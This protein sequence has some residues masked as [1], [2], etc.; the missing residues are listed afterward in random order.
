MKTYHQTKLR[1]CALAAAFLFA[2]APALTAATVQWE[3]D[4]EHKAVAAGGNAMPAKSSV[5]WQF[6]RPDSAFIEVTDT[7]GAKLNIFSAHPTLEKGRFYYTDRSYGGAKLKF[8]EW[9][10]GS[11]FFELTSRHPHTYHCTRD[12]KVLALAPVNTKRDLTPDMTALGF[13]RDAHEPFQFFGENPAD[14]FASFTKNLRQGDTLALPPWVL[15]AGFDVPRTPLPGAG[16]LLYNGLRFPAPWP[17]KVDWSHWSSDLPPAEA[18][19]LKNRPAVV[20]IDIGRQLFVDDFLVESTDLEREFHYPEKFAGNPVLKPETEIELKGS[21]DLAVAA[22]KSGGLWWSPEKQLFELWY[23]AGWVRTI[24]YA[25]SRDGIHWHRPDL[26]L[27]PG[28]NQVLPAGIPS[29]SYSVVRDYDTADPRKKF[30]LFLRAGRSRDRVRYATSPDGI[31]WGDIQTGGL[32]GDRSTMFYNPFR[33]K[34]VFTLRWNSPRGRARAY[35]ETSDFERGIHWLPD[36]PFPWARA[37]KLD[38]PDPRI[39]DKPQLYNLDAVAY[40]SLMLGCFEILHGPDNNIGAAQG[41]PKFTGLHFAYSRDGFHWHRPD[42]KMAVNSEQ[43]AG[44]WDRGYVQSLNNLCVIRGDKI[45]FYYIGF[46]GDENIRMGENGV[47]TSMKSG[48]YANAATGIATLRRDGFVSMNAGATGGVLL[49][50]PVSFSGARLFVNADIPR[51]T[52]SV[53]I[54]DEAGAAIVPFTFANCV[55]FTGDST[56]AAINWKNGGDLSRLAGKPVR[57]RF[58]LPP[59]AKLY[60]F[61]VSRDESGR[62]DGYVAGGGPGYTGA[63]DTVGQAALDAEARLSGRQ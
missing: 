21:G 14:I 12:G 3:N 9:L 18:P 24:A 10:E 53:E 25:T 55:P 28:T 2:A 43:T 4:R 37:D 7:P 15:L 38:L 48:L 42:R 61:W 32:S 29:D 44:K 31:N 45:W 33:K 60:S 46:A 17:P 36:E 51:G 47:V 39:G 41:I 27:N 40:E 62:S 20:P 49:T 8:P 59:A 6:D 22:P 1:A 50:R 19:W 11:L 26:P 54:C 63:T 34:W 30:K 16:E 35:W 58:H 56:L 23:E 57:I 5:R 13:T 52:L